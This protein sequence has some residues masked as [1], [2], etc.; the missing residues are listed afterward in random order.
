LA[1]DPR[2]AQA[3]NNLGV[4]LREKLQINEA[5]D[6]HR[7]AIAIQGDYA[8]AHFALGWTLLLTGSF[9]DG[10]REYE[11]RLRRKQGSLLERTWDGSELG[12]KRILLHAEQGFGDT[13][14]FARYVPMV[15][16]CGGEVLLVC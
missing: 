8:D 15:A 10:W 4:A 5:M 7:R 13:I 11:W 9:R 3:W 2:Y 1:L 12:E 14:Q 6:A 16:Q